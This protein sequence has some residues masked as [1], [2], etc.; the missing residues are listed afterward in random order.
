MEG[1]ITLSAIEIMILLIF[2]LLTVLIVVLR[3]EPGETLASIIF[4]NSIE[5]LSFPALRT[6]ET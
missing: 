6:L 4:N 2:P 5:I 1:C 3:I